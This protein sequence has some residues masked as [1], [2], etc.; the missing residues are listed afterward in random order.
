MPIR[1]PAAAQLF[2]PLQHP[3][4]LFLA[5]VAPAEQVQQTVADNLRR[6]TQ[7]QPASAGSGE[8]GS[9]SSQDAEADDSPRRKLLP[10]H[11]GVVVALPLESGYFE[12]WLSGVI[13]IK[14]HGFAMRTGG[15]QGRGR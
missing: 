6:A 14:G 11:V 10:C 4:P 2:L 15:L 13:S 9:D 7:E 1:A 8:A 12:D 5:V 3:P